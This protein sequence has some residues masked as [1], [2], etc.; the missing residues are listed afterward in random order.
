MSTK[1]QIP[2]LV[3]AATALVGSGCKKDDPKPNIVFILAD[4]LGYTQMGFDGSHY[5]QTPYLDKLASEGMRFT[6]AYA[7]CSVCSPTRASIM[8]GKYPARLH[9]TDFIPG[10]KK[11]GYPLSQPDWQKFLPLEEVTFAE[12]LKEKGYNTALFGKWHL[13]TN[14]L[15]PE[16][17]PYNPDKQGFNEVFITH[18]PSGLDQPWQDAENDSHNIDTLTSRSLEFLEK[19]KSNPFF[20]FVSHNAIHS[21]LKEKA[22]SIQKYK[23][24]QGSEEPENNPVIGAM[25][26]R[27]DSS[28]GKIFNKLSELGL[29]ENTLIIFFADNGGLKQ[30]ASQA[31][32]REGKGWFYEGGIKEPLIVKWKDVV[33]PATVS[34]SLVSSIDFF[35]TFL[36]IAGITTIPE[37]VDGKS[38]VPVLKDPEAEIHQTLFWH[39]PHYHNGPPCGVI[40][41]GKWKLIEW[42]DNSLLNTGKPAY[43]LFDLENDISESVSLAD[44]MKTLTLKLAGELQ[45]W[46]KD[47]NAQM[48]VPNKRK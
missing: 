40:R 44:S 17:L 28:C 15:P 42:Y 4:D 26:E 29:E 13:S 39:F 47:V 41:N 12:K 34:K 6:N 14:Y 3:F 38:L 5:Y 25:I 1:I 43:E 21:P 24:R 36:E 7:A 22:A 8:T 30:D 27:L 33:A 18:K 35:P 37:N 32:L 45:R 20:L 46:R 31:P 48:P 16:S 23:N 11:D 10:S 2:L 19:N 9:I